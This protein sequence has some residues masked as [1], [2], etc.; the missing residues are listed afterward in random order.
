MNH[1]TTL[2]ISQG[3][4]NAIEGH[5]WNSHQPRSALGVAFTQG[6]RRAVANPRGAKSRKR[7]PSISWEGGGMMGLRRA[8]TLVALATSSAR[9][10]ISHSGRVGEW[11]HNLVFA[12]PVLHVCHSR[13][14]VRTL[15]TIAGPG[16]D[17]KVVVCGQ[18]DGL[19]GLIADRLMAE[20]G[21]RSVLMAEES[22]TLSE[23]LAGAKVVVLTSDGGISGEE[24]PTGLVQ[25]VVSSLPATVEYLLWVDS[26]EA[27]AAFEEVRK[28]GGGLL[29]ALFGGIKDPLVA[30]RDVA[31]VKPLVVHTGRLFGVGMGKVPVPFT[32]GPKADPVIDESYTRQAVLVGP[33][34]VLSKAQEAAS[35][36][37]SVA[38]AVRRILAGPERKGGLDLSV[39]SVEGLETTPE[40]WDKEFARLDDSEGMAV[41]SMDFAAINKREALLEW[42]VSSWGAGTLRKTSATMLRSGARPVSILPMEGGVQVVWETVDDDLRTVIAGKLCVLVKDSPAGLRVVRQNGQG[43]PLPLTLSGEEEIVQSLIEGINTVAYP[44]GYITRKKVEAVTLIPGE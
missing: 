8:A 32:T 41:F 34:T 15:M 4:R 7:K 36:R 35:K 38:E 17:A 2:V 14:P 5:G 13:A 21:S 39:V 40:E 20:G 12:Q 6:R 27:R 9:A 19:G 28:E 33:G 3:N 43:E 25:E 37:S 26:P 11:G 30:V 31:G 29:D 22:K 18:A 42:L 44:R 24:A 23:Q 1:N 16:D 10:F